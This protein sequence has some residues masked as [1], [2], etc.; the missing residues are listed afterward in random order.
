M[1]KT[2]KTKKSK[3]LGKS[4]VCKNP[5]GEI[6]E[7]YKLVFVTKQRK[8]YSFC[9]GLKNKNRI[10][11]KF[12]RIQYFLNKWVSPKNGNGPLAVFDSLSSVYDFLAYQRNYSE[13][14]LNKTRLY[15]CSYVESERRELFVLDIPDLYIPTKVSLDDLPKGTNLANSVKLNERV[16]LIIGEKRI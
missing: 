8:F 1:S 9:S 15:S 11:K 5:A 12:W 4:D 10:P 2:N 14:V 16:P 7:G 3:P 6:K 13:E